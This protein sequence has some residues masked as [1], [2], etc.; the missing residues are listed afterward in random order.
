MGDKKR[1]TGTSHTDGH[2]A[3][4]K[5]AHQ[6]ALISIQAPAAPVPVDAN[7]TMRRTDAALPADHA[8]WAAI[9]NR[10][11]AIGFDKYDRFISRVLCDAKDE[12]APVSGDPTIEAADICSPTIR[13][14]RRDLLKVPS[15]YG[16]DAFLL[17]EA[18]VAVQ[19][20]RNPQTGKITKGDFNDEVPGEE[21][22]IGERVTFKE[23][24]QDLGSY[25]VG[26][27]TLPYLQ[28]IVDA[29]VGIG[30]E[31]QK[32]DLPFCDNLLKRRLTSPSMIELI[33]SY[34][35]EEGML[36]QT[37]NAVS[38][39]FQNKRGT[40]DHDPLANLEIDALRPLSNILWGFI[41]DE[42]SRLSIVRRVYEYAHLY[43][44]VM[45]GKAAPNLRPAD[46]RLKF[47]EAFHNLLYRAGLF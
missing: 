27:T 18:G 24:S 14:R 13:D 8:L 46:T 43:G 37:M 33:W 28:R 47:I 4:A 6:E 38:L 32:E 5:S 21:G 30:S 9:R 42:G 15:I 23:L 11:D 35:N 1:Q 34:W 25:L 31:R 7:V 26:G 36:V 20:P 41:Q 10:T 29:L 40:A 2:L 44:L 39:R 17:F 19:P 16:V 22:R 12:G 45:Q 3:P